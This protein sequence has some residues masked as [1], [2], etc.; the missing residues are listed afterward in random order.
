MDVETAGGLKLTQ[1][2]P[3]TLGK[4]AAVVGNVALGA[5]AIFA[6]NVSGNIYKNIEKELL[7]VLGTELKKKSI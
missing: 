4:I 2:S 6:K 5:G 3:T 1:S 7:K